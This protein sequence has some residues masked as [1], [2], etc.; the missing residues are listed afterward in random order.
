MTSQWLKDVQADIAAGDLIELTDEEWRARCE[1]KEQAERDHK[2]AQAQDIARRFNWNVHALRVQASN[3]LYALHWTTEYDEYPIYRR[4][5]KIAELHM[6]DDDGDTFD[7]RC[8]D[9]GHTPETGA[10]FYCKM[11]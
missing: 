6:P 1:A 9:C 8:P 11:D 10:C 7:A 2:E 5:Q 4:A 3:K